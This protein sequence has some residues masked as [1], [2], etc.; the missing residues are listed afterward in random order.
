MQKKDQPPANKLKAP[1]LPRNPK[2]ERAVQK[3]AKVMRKRP[4]AASSR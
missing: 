1:T 2:F 4:G 3:V